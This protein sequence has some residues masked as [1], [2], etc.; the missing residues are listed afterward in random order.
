LKKLILVLSIFPIT[1]FKNGLRITTLS[2]LGAY[3][4]PRIL[5]SQLHRSGGIPFFFIALALLAP[6]LWYLMKKEKA[7]KA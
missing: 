4:D 3:Y 7:H 1:V 5:D 6:V 2:L